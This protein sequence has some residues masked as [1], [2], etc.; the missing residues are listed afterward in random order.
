MVIN[1]IKQ[2]IQIHV[3]TFLAAGFPSKISLTAMPS[4]L[5]AMTDRDPITEH[6]VI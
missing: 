2:N 6:I 1:T 5:H 4:P 3:R